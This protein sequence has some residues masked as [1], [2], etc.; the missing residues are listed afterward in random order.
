[1][2]QRLE[3]HLQTD[4]RFPDGSVGWFDLNL[5]PIP[6]GVAIFS[7]DITQRKEAE[8][9]IRAIHADLERRVAERTAELV[10]ARQAAEAASLAKSRFLANMSHEIRTPLH[11][12]I[13]LTS[14]LRAEAS[15]PEV[16]SRLG[17]IDNAAS[18]LLE[19]I[20]DVLDL[21][22]I[23]AGGL[24]LERIAFSLRDVVERS[25]ALVADQARTKGLTLRSEVQ[26]GD[27]VLLGDPTRLS[28]ALVN[29]LSN[30][31]KFTE[32][33]GITVQV[34][35]QPTATRDQVQVRFAVHDTGVG[36]AADA[37]QQ[38]FSAFVQA[39]PSTTRRYG[40]T[41]L[42]L[43]ITRRLAALMGGQAGGKST[44]GVGSEFWFTGVFGR[45]HEPH[46][47][48]AAAPTD[49]KAR[50]RAGWAGALVLLV[51]DDPVNQL[52]AQ[53]MLEAAGLAVETVDSGARA[54]QR[55]SEHRHALILMD[56]QMPGMDGL[57]ATRRIRQLP[58]CAQ[59]P[60]VAMTA[61]AFADDRQACLA[62]GMNAHI[63][64]PVRPERLY[65]T[66]LELLEADAEAP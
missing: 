37:L 26:A 19:I 36:I 59:V 44:P 41:G 18:H 35:A 65:A 34:S 63:A 30:A 50:L 49:G 62:A 43:A 38:L 23:E 42:G 28:Q 15:T 58:G 39:D 46:K 48:P 1:M 8:E 25:C 22:K 61:N 14:L 9:E 54:V 33:G 60:I 5:Q 13:G 4:S 21:S 6:E 55:A 31:V 51:E 52:V 20:N 27:D 11:A 57:Q 24:A 66:L 2:A 16:A 29:L 3:L 53:S 40:G 17:L 56:M 64:K 12:I 32:Q 7:V 45:S 47:L 10:Q